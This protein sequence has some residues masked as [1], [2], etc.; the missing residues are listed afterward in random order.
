VSIPTAGIP[1]A[2]HPAR[3]RA[4]T[5]WDGRH[6]QVRVEDPH[7][8]DRGHD[9][10][11]HRVDVEATAWALVVDA[12]AGDPAGNVAVDLE[13]QLPHDIKMRFELIAGLV[14][15]AIRELDDVVEALLGM[16]MSAVDVVALLNDQPLNVR[17]SRPLLVP[18]ADV[19]L[20]G[21]ANR[22]DAVALR[23]E[24]GP[25]VGQVFC[26]PCVDRY[27]DRWRDVPAGVSA[28][29]YTGPGACHACGALIHATAATAVE[30]TPAA[31]GP[32]RRE[33]HQ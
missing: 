17:P 12:V 14:G 27:R 7:G 10:A 2:A 11:D 20:F 23:W 25:L 33:A 15:D 13:V 1:P 9:T 3:Y 32:T 28:L 19:A 4:V 5:R 16:N 24:A 22:P 26:R 30:R 29:I 18:N 6:W 21:V 8:V 31:S